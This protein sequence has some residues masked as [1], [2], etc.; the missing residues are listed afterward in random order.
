MIPLLALALPLAQLPGGDAARFSACTAL[1][2][3]DAARA[4]TE[5]EG[6]AGQNKTLPA[7][8]CLGLAYAATERWLPAAST[9]EQAAQQAQADG[10]GRA[11]TLWSEA[12]NAALAADDPKR[13]RDLLDRALALPALPAVVAGE[14]WVDR[15]RADFALDDM[16]GARGDLDHAVRLVSSDPFAWLLS[17]TLARKQGDLPRAQADIAQAVQ[18][19]GDDPAVQ[20]EAGNTAA[21]ADRRDEARQAWTRAAQLG[22]DTPEGKAAS[23]ALAANKDLP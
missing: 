20:L 19:A 17:A 2:R 10:D 9:F 16:A 3:T 12:G 13:A 6:W 22:P 23:A 1:I 15:A 18:L 8:H 7:R 4:V 14:A 5:A 21:A 11:A